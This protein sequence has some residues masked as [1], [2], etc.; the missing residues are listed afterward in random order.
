MSRPTRFFDAVQR[1][2]GPTRPSLRGSAKLTGSPLASY[3]RRVWQP[4][5]RNTSKMVKTA[6]LMLQKCSSQ[7]DE[8]NRECISLREEM[9]CTRQTLCDI[10]NEKEHLNAK[11]ELSKS[12]LAKLRDKN[13][14]LE[15]ECL[16]LIDENLDLQLSEENSDTSS[17][18]DVDSEARFQAIIGHRK[19]SPEIRKLYYSLLAD[20]VPA[21][22]IASVIQTV[23]KCFHPTLDVEELRLPQKTAASYMRKDELKTVSQAHNVSCQL[24]ID[25][26]SRCT[27][28]P[29]HSQAS[30]M[31]TRC[32][33]RP[34]WAST[35][36]MTSAWLQSSS[37]DR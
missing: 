23:L 34:L 7:V 11:C 15:Q 4:R 13:E 18:E 16:D 17:C 24:H 10:T 37:R 8:L 6:G 9:K 32:T 30:T 29:V 27:L 33:L 3:R 2:V 26:S 5:V 31:P 1:I 20:Q 14:Q 28:R 22:K 36:H 19:Y 21:S 25:L 12:K 35:V